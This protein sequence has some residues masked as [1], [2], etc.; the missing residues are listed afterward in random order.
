M[1]F[2]ALTPKKKKTKQQ[3]HTNK[4]LRHATHS[5]K[6]L[7]LFFSG[8]KHKHASEHTHTHTHTL[9]QYTS[10][11]LAVIRGHIDTAD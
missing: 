10:T 8:R 7:S 1:C 6:H 11:G 4:M 9:I 5:S 3:Q 2:D